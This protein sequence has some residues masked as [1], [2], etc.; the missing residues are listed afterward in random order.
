MSKLIRIQN[1]IKAIN[2]AKFQY[3]CDAYLYRK[4][5]F[6]RIKTIGSVI[7]KEKTAKGTPDTLFKNDKGKFAFAEYTTQ[8]KG[9]VDKFLEDLDKCFNEEKTKVPVS[10]IEKIFL[11]YNGKI[12]VEVENRL[13]NKG[14]EKGVRVEL[15]DIETLSFDLFLNYQR[16]SEEF[17]GIE[18]DTGQILDAQDFVREYQK[19]PI[20]TRLDTTF[21]CRA[22]ELVKTVRALENKELVI[23]SGK[24]GIGKSRLALEAIDRFVKKNPGFRNYCIYNKEGISLYN[25]LKDYFSNDGNYLIFVDD[26]DRLSELQHILRLLSENSVHKHYKIII[27]VRDYALRKIRE[28]AKGYD[29]N[30]IILEPF[31]SKK[32]KTFLAE[33]FKITTPIYVERIEKISEGNPRI[34]VMAAE[35]AKKANRLDSIY[36]VS[37]IYDE[38]FSSISKDL[39]SFENQNLLKVAGLLSF[40]K[41]IKFEDKELLEKIENLFGLSATE[42]FER[43]VEL[44][45]I[46][47][48]DFYEDEVVKISDQILATYLF[49]KVFFKDSLLKFSVLL[50][51][52]FESHRHLLI[53]SIYPAFDAFDKKLLGDKLQPAIDVSWEQVKKDESSALS[54]IETFFP[55]I[56]TESILL[57]KNIIDSIPNELY[58]PLNLEFEP[59]KSNQLTDKYLR[60]LKLFRQL[61][62]KTFR[63]AVSLLFI[64]LEKR[65]SLA[66]QVVYLIQENVCFERNS[67][68]EGYVYEQAL[69]EQLIEK[70]KHSPRKELFQRLF[71]KIVNR[72]VGMQFRSN[73]SKKEAIVIH[74]FGL[75]TGK[76]IFEL[77]KM[78]WQELFNYFT[79]E[80]YQDSVLE[81]LSIYSGNWRENNN[82]EVA[83]EDKKH[84]VAF[85]K[86]NL[87]PTIYTHCCA[88]QDYGL[89]LKK[90]KI[91]FPK[92]LQQNFISKT[93]KTAEIILDKHHKIYREVRPEPGITGY[94]KHRVDLLK[95]ELGELTAEDYIDF[96]ETCREIS[97]GNSKEIYQ[98]HS[99]IFP[100]LNDLADT[101]RD[102]FKKVILH[103]LQTGNLLHL[104]NYGVHQIV[105]HIV[106]TF[107]TAKEAFEFL[108]KHDY[109]SK[110][111]WL[112]CF[113]TILVEDEINDFILTE[114]F[115]HYKT[116]DL[117]LGD[118][119]YLEKYAHLDKEIII[120]IVGIV[121]ERIT[122]SGF[123]FNFFYLLHG[124]L[125]GKF[126]EIFSKDLKLL[127]QIYFYQQ[128]LE[129]YAD[130]GRKVF[131][132]ICE[133]DSDFVIEFLE[134]LYEQN[135]FLPESEA[136][137]DYYFIWESETF[138]KTI[139]EALEFCYKKPKTPYLFRNYVKI[140]FGKSKKDKVNQT[141]KEFLSNYILENA[142][143]KE[144][145]S[146]VFEVI[147]DCPNLHNDIRDY[148][149][150]FLKCN[151]DYEDFRLLS[152]KPSYEV[153]WEKST[154][155]MYEGEIAFYK[156][157]LPLVEDLEYIEHRNVIERQ[158]KGFRQRIQQELKIEFI[159]SAYK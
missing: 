60:I 142:A 133:M 126:D 159:E 2:Q 75:A 123:L 145:M 36:N 141:I 69:L 100:L 19:N 20:A 146:F 155:P 156:S 72:F 10:G 52:F 94:Q 27:T 14:R 73:S 138:E 106:D 158:I 99:V 9:L 148:L 48:A 105:R 61:S 154:I 79:R 12:S 116:A 28:Q 22:R 139:T 58:E 137:R 132:K 6:T 129:N 110:E 71:L 151:K 62:L 53:D 51:N 1:E 21:R 135:S 107:S 89:F 76:E 143:D 43:S 17:L 134:F 77:R 149:A 87:D 44:N 23:I 32:L 63:K 66:P 152:I 108:K 56:K 102:I 55:F 82:K 78:L 13:V 130:Y 127:K 90:L 113:F 125:L 57:L 147:A 3:L 11:G 157:L 95:N 112:S 38:Y 136:N 103:I 31:D 5:N 46:E 117:L 33:E 140:Y 29:Y 68:I 65:P 124:D 64:Y 4:Y 45:N 118:F 67:H 7:G 92:K 39:S 86:S 80:Q 97:S 47:V 104:T 153:V 131:Q 81:T 101:D 115:N 93:Y 119:E 88:V 16:L 26:A 34:A 96:L 74:T 111:F 8:E 144:K 59:Y 30:E 70:T 98:L 41:V 122:K 49:Y 150:N 15:I 109:D 120:K 91:P 114:L 40:F 25:D 37:E 54:F 128:K 50:D 35:I 84:I 24:A 85:I 42:I 18:V 83:E 121:W